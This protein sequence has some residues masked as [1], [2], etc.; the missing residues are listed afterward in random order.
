MKLLITGF[1]EVKLPLMPVIIILMLCV[2]YSSVDLQSSCIEEYSAAMYRS[3][4]LCETTTRCT[5][6]V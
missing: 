2:L 5:Y 3:A 1:F 4:T 6:T